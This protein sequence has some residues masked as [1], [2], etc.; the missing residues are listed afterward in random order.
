MPNLNVYLVEGYSEAQKET[1]L[2]RMTDAVVDSIAAPKASVRI[3]L[4]ELPRA[5]ICAG[6]VPWPPRRELAGRC[7]RAGRR[8]TPSDPR[9]HGCPEGGPD[10]PPDGCRRRGAGHSAG[11]RAGNGVRCGQYGFRHARRHRQIPRALNCRG[12]AWWCNSSGR[13]TAIWRYCLGVI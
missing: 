8:S 10:R 13:C 1:L 4:I 7:R 12:G 6:G 11:P 5:H 2:V 3:F 9:A